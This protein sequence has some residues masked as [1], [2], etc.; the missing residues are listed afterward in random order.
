[1]TSFCTRLAPVTVHTQ[2][3]E[4][5]NYMITELRHFCNLLNNLVLPVTPPG[6][7]QSNIKQYGY[8]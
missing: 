4:S 3:N 7:C 5:F 1:M 8:E 2:Y 6:T